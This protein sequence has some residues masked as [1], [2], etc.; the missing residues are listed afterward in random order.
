MINIKRVVNRILRSTFITENQETHMH[1]TRQHVTQNFD[2]GILVNNVPASKVELAGMYLIQGSDGQ[3][4]TI[5][6]EVSRPVITMVGAQTIGLQV[7]DVWSEPGVS[8]Q[9][10]DGTPLAVIT[11][12][13]V[14]TANIGAMQLVYTAVSAQ[15]DI[16]ESKIRYIVVTDTTA[17][18]L[19][20]VGGN[21]SL[22]LGATWGGE[23]G[24]S[25]I[26]NN[27][28]DG[29]MTSQVVITGWNGDTSQSG[30][31]T[32]TYTCPADSQ[33][34]G[35]VTITRQITIA[36][37]TPISLYGYHASSVAFTG[38][39]SI[40]SQNVSSGAY[41]YNQTLTVARVFF[42]V[43]PAWGDYSL[44]AYSSVPANT[45][46]F[47]V[48]DMTT[49]F[50]SYSVKQFKMSGQRFGGPVIQ[51]LGSSSSSGPWTLLTTFSGGGSNSSGGVLGISTLSSN[52]T[53]YRYLRISMNN[54]SSVA[55]SSD[56]VLNRFSLLGTPV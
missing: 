50:E 39:P 22:V 41:T 42:G 49:A 46:Y 32:R 11:T 24:Y 5:G 45:E 40:V 3:T 33:G 10:A 51:M 31:F 25:A 38:T 9:N 29:D 48:M 28:A 37:P 20:L 13:T 52:S 14:S 19:T 2:S 30:S 16:A 43:A 27:P 36:P 6:P 35:P 54:T 15:G 44:G 1:Q 17:P 26:D 7:G 12:G 34:N 56:T 23:H 18:V 4:A 21:I 55:V 8:A 53:G 47:V